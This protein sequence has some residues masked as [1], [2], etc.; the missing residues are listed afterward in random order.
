M[1]LAF[2]PQMLMWRMTYGHWL[3]N[4]SRP[5]YLG[6]PALLQVLFSPRHGLFLWHP[7]LLVGLAGLVALARRPGLRRL[8]VAALLVFAAQVVINAMPVDWWGNAGFG[9]RRFCSTLPLLSLGLAYALSKLPWL[10]PAPVLAAYWNFGLLWALSSQSDSGKPLL[11][12][13]DPLTI[14]TARRVLWHLL[15]FV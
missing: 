13:L 2:F 10:A 3:V 4:A 5:G 11:T 1:L 12:A 7:L 15:F 9:A 8:A 14:E 6:R